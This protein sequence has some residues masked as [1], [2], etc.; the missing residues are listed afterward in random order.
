M[1][2]YKRVL[3]KLSGETLSGGNTGKF[4]EA[5]T[6]NVARQ[7]KLAV[8]EGLQVGIV[9]GGGNF[10]RGRSSERMDRSKA[11]EI[12]MM[13]T[14]LN[15][16]YAAAVFRMVGLETV[17]M[18]PFVVG[19]FTELY[20]K[21]AMMKHLQD[22]K[23]VFFAGGTGH[24]YFSTDTGAALRAIQMEADTILLAKNIDGIYDKD[25][26]QFAD[27][28]RFEEITLSDVIARGL[29]VMDM[30]AAQLCLEN[31]MSMTV[32]HFGAENAIL[33]AAKGNNNG[34]VVIPE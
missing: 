27:A 13:A 17:I 2:K 26:N 22:G 33:E 5:S 3:L 31:K 24:P 8:D 16:Q 23:V 11:D 25:P 30:T 19:T 21:E 4:D 20:S 10:W 6:L 18:T 32:F 9:T 28:V 12:G 34:T 1:L 7:V 29:K 14:V 15:C